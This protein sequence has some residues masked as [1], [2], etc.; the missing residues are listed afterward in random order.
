MM[1]TRFFIEISDSEFHPPVVGH[2]AVL[3]QM[4]SIAK[5]AFQMETV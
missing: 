4:R 2:A 5:D 3:M 1:G